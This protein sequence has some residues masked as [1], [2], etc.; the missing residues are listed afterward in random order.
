V[1]LGSAQPLTEMNVG[2]GGRWVVLTTLPPSCAY[3]LEI[4]KPQPP[5]LLILEV[6]KF[7]VGKI[8]KVLDGNFTRF[9]YV[10]M[11]VCMYVCSWHMCLLVCTKQYVHLT[12]NCWNVYW[13]VRVVGENCAFPKVSQP[14]I[15]DKR[16]PCIIYVGSYLEDYRLQYCNTAVILT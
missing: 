4:W 14:N 3:C 12:A 13:K 1:A 11:Y 8:T 5:S 2:V 7:N 9:V 16:S 6:A 10:C 15:G